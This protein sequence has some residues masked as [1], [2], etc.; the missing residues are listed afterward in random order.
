VILSSKCWWEDFSAIF[1]GI[2][3]CFGAHTQYI[4]WGVALSSIVPTDSYL[5]IVAAAAALYSELTCKVLKCGWVKFGCDFSHHVTFKIV[6][7]EIPLQF[8][9]YDLL[10]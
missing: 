9:R 3:Y 10:I 5:P 8:H 1:V 4:F 7:V 2:I 6:V